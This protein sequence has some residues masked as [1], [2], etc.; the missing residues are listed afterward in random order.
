VN[1]I[2]RALPAGAERRRVL[3]KCGHC[4]VLRARTVPSPELLSEY[5][6]K[7]SLL[8]EGRG[9]GTGES[10]WGRRTA[11]AHILELA[12]EIGAG[13]V[14]DVG[15]NDG[16]LLALLPERLEKH[17]VD[18]SR[19]ACARAAARGIH[20]HCGTLFDAPLEGGF[21]L[22]CAL[23]VL[24]HVENPGAVLD[25]MAA[26][27]AP[28]G[29]LFIQTG[30]AAS[31]AARLLGAD[32]YYPAVYGHLTVA[33]PK[34]LRLRAERLGLRERSLLLG[35]HEFA[36]FGLRLRRETAA[37]ILRAARLAASPFENIAGGLPGVRSIRRRWPVPAPFRD[38][39]VMTL[40]KP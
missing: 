21:D 27:L 36:S 9:R 2:P 22:I 35:R 1:L 30:N 38:H 23:D 24:E 33:T 15:C 10:P 28:D 40:E 31:L 3:D 16:S 20:A 6:E 39:F 5:Y 25:R 34:A 18:V 4:G 14:L 17:G 29:R 11:T 26:L 7:Y 19:D 8:E 12:Q 37:F 13:R 32:W